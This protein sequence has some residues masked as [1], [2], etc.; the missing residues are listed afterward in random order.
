MLPTRALT[1]FQ[2]FAWLVASGIKDLENRPEGF[3]HKSFRGEFWIHAAVYQKQAHLFAFEVCL[4]VLG[5]GFRLPEE[6]ELAYGAIIGRATVTGI[7]APRSH[8]TAI[9]PYVPHRWHFP[10]EWGFVLG[11]PQ[12]LKEPVPC[13]GYQGFWRVPAPVLH[14]LS[15]A[16]NGSAA[17]VAP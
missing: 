13:R 1:L 3:S 7:L 16:E 17:P 10:D 11:S 9:A 14:E 12:M 2:P 15:V 5:E 8:A 6:A 4:D